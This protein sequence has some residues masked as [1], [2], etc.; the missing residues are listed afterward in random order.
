M[1][2]NL[3][4]SKAKTTLTVN[5]VSA[6]TAKP[7]LNKQ[8]TFK[9][10]SVVDK[11]EPLTE[12]KINTKYTFYCHKMTLSAKLAEENLCKFVVY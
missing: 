1:P 6:K 11:F 5:N 4:I 10:V 12:F 9:L 7:W 3:G 2:M 8:I